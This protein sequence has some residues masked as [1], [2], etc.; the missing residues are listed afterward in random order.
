M[1]QASVGELFANGLSAISAKDWQAYRTLFPAQPKLEAT[2]QPSRP[3][4]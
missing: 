1:P 4:R 2:N 3:A